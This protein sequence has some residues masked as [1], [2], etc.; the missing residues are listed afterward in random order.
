MVK[1]RHLTDYC[2]M[3]HV[4]GLHRS[5]WATVVIPASSAVVIVVVIMMNGKRLL[6]EC[7]RNDWL[8]DYARSWMSNLPR[9]FI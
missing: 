1:T 5:V 9:Y 2:V 8:K 6:L 7:K 3:I 4:T